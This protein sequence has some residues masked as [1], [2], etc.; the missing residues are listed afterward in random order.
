MAQSYWQ[1]YARYRVNRRRALQGAAGV[2]TG[3]AAVAIVGCGGDGNG[4][5]GN[6]NGNGTTGPG[7]YKPQD[8]TSGA[9]TG[10][11]LRDFI[12]TDVVSFDPL[13]S[14]SFNTQSSVAYFTYPRL[15]RF[16]TEKYPDKA[17][18]ESEG[19]LAT[20]HEVSEDKLQ[21][22]FRL[23]PG[24][25]WESRAPT[26]GREIDAEDVVFSWNKFASVS[27]FRGDFA[28]S[29][30]NAGAPVESV[31]APDNR[32]VVFRLHQPDSSIVQLF[33]T[34][35]LFFV[36]PRESEG[37]FDPK[38]EVRGYGP[39]LLEEFQPSA[40]HVW[41][42]APEYFI[43]GRPFLDRIERPIVP[44]YATR[45]GQFKAGNIWTTVVRA[46]DVAATKRDVPDLLLT[47]DEQY[48]PNPT[49]FV[50]FGYEGN[51]PFKDERMRQAVS[52]LIDRELM[53]DV[54]GNRD[55]FEAEG[56]E[57]PFRLHTVVGAGWDGFWID[58]SS[59]DFGDNGKLLTFDPAEAKKLMSAAGF[60]NGVDTELFYNQGSQYGST[61][62]RVAEVLVSMFSDGGI[63]ARQSP[64]DYQTDYLPNYYYAYAAGNTKGFNGIIYGAE[65]SYPT[66]SSQLYATMHRAGPRFHGM[67]PNGERAWEGDPQ[68]NQMIER[69]RTE[70]DLE[71]QQDLSQEFARFMT[72]KAYNVPFP[73]DALGY[74]LYWP[75]IGNL[76]VFDT[77]VGGN[78]VSETAL[79][80]WVDDSKPP[81][82]RS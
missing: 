55:Q 37:G 76:Q 38:G 9:K 5:D 44:E 69:I 32:T 23:R 27:P 51:S 31:S 56:L 71:R 41:R 19:E 60:P 35:I 33:T 14:S 12:T 18:G 8:T 13:S 70:F 49:S 6:G 58:P 54:I 68:V 81:V 59:N 67:T 39:Y 24:L 34:A 3:I 28:Y 61:Y 66:L 65:R 42:K 46:E 47:Q 82:G 62:T 4:G 80:W 77:F 64:K 21:V 50:S 75:A 20:S 43:Q 30:E 73:F 48:D 17:T 79:H 53:L 57:L 78:A 74:G 40:L 63:R 1:K 22:T 7:V 26:N 45:L 16:K 29:A 15:L 2:G 72:G 36:M 11:T 52:L 10:G 25:K